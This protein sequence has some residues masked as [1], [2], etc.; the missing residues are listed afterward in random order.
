ME[1]VEKEKGVP[2]GGGVGNDVMNRDMIWT[3]L[4]H[5]AGMEGGMI[6]D[7]PPPG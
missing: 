2:V 5:G 7:S 6:K 4:V 1:E 3:I